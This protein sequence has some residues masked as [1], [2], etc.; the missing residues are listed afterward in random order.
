MKA[1]DQSI[2]SVVHVPVL[3]PSGSEP[4]IECTK[5]GQIEHNVTSVLPCNDTQVQ[6][7]LIGMHS[8]RTAP[9]NCTTTTDTLYKT[10]FCTL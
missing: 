6:T 8:L 9:E 3:C 2:G 4:V 7:Q 1:Q 5:D 10:I